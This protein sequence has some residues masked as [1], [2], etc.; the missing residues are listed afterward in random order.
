MSGSLNVT[1]IRLEFS[2]DVDSV[3]LPGG[4]SLSYDA[5][6]KLIVEPND[7]VVEYS[8]VGDDVTEDQNFKDNG[9]FT[10]EEIGNI[11]IRAE[12]RRRCKY[13]F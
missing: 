2:P 8:S 12:D 7:V 4:T 5:S 6:E 1:I 9:Q 10:I 11:K 13:V 3:Y